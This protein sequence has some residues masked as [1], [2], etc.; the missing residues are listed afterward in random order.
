MQVM[1]NIAL[2]VS[3]NFEAVQ[4]NPQQIVK[5]LAR[6]SCQLVKGSGNAPMAKRIL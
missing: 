6:I 4:N 3:K 2:S 1:C 5:G